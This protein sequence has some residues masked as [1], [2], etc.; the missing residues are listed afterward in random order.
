MRQKLSCIGL[1]AFFALATIF[2]VL[3][4]AGEEA[5]PATGDELRQRFREIAANSDDREILKEWETLSGM[6]VWTE[7]TAQ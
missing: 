5:S 4:A 7:A 2:T 6:R 3:L 1:V